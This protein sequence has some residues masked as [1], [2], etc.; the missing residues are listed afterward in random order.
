V[1]PAVIKEALCQAAW[2]LIAGS[3]LFAACFGSSHF[4]WL[5][6]PL[7]HRIDNQLRLD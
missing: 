3:V 1:E 5:C 2:L 7:F 4:W 6:Q